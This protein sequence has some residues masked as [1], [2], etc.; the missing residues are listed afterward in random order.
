L[1]TS[2]FEFLTTKAA[3]RAH[4]AQ[5][6]GKMKEKPTCSIPYSPSAPLW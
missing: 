3:G 4:K 2:L 1:I 5:K 6:E